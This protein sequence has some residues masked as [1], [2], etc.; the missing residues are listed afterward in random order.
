MTAHDLAKAFLAKGLEDEIL[1]GKVLDDAEVDDIF[2]FHVQ[3]ALEKYIKAVPAAEEIPPTRSHDLGV[4][5]D[6]VKTTGHDVPDEFAAGLSGP[7]TQ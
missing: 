1:L 2:G 3:Q 5:L 7:D 4:L 6:Q